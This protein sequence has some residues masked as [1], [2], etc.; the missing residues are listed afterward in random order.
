MKVLSMCWV[1]LGHR[2][3]II[4]EIS[5]NLEEIQDVR[6]VFQFVALE[7]LFAFQFRK[8]WYS[9]YILLAHLAVDTFFFIS[10]ALMT[11][12]FLKTMR[13][14]GQKFNVFLFYLH[15]YIR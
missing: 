1:I 7:L 12:G 2:F 4:S 8:A 14:P 15:R 5:V 3:S 6:W 9:F 11:Y 10:G 13:K